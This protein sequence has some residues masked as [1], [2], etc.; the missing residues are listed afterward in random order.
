KGLVEFHSKG[1][2]WSNSVGYDGPAVIRSTSDT[3]FTAKNS[4]A[5]SDEAVTTT[6][7]AA[8][9]DTNIHLHSVA[10][11]GGGLGS[12]LV[13]SIGWKR[14]Q[15]SRGQAESI[16]AK[17]AENRIAN[18]FNDELDDEVR[19]ARKR[20]EDEYRRPLERRGEVPDHIRFSS[21]KNSIGF[22]VTQAS[23]SEL[24]ATGSPPAVSE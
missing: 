3:D 7:A 8:D 16:A 18:K 23:H 1:H 22:E 15:G 2:V 14:A 12:R 24:G 21:D 13:S 5:V 6:S 19:K 9:A 20:Y 11:Q 10:K 4:G 17:H